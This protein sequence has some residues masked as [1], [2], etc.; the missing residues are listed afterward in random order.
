MAIF[1][2][3]QLQNWLGFAEIQAQ[4]K[5]DCAREQERQARLIQQKCVEELISALTSEQTG[6]IW[7]DSW[8][9]L[10]KQVSKHITQTH[11][12]IKKFESKQSIS[13]E[14]VAKNL[15][16]LP[17]SSTEQNNELILENQQLKDRLVLSHQIFKSV[18]DVLAEFNP[19]LQE[20]IADT[21][22][23][24]V[25]VLTMISDVDQSADKLVQYL[26]MS[27]GE[28]Q[29]MNANIEADSEAITSLGGFLGE[30]VKKL[31]DDLNS[32]EGVA[33]SIEA[34]KDQV[35][36]VDNISRQTTLL[37]FNATIEAARAGIHGKGFAIVAA[38]VRKLA[39]M[40]SEASHKIGDSI[41]QNHKYIQ[42]YLL[43]FRA[44]SEHD[45]EKVT[46]LSEKASKLAENY[47]AQRTF[48]KILLEVVQSSNKELS[49]KI[50]NV[51]GQ[52][53][54]QDI[55]RQRVERIQNAISAKQMILADVAQRL[56][57]VGQ[58]MEP[59]ELNAL[60][61]ELD[62]Y[63]EEDSRHNAFIGN[64]ALDVAQGQ[65]EGMKIDL[66]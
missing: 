11:Q 14:P 49:R 37:S 17:A 65:S 55:V 45:A 42:N 47:E 66:F 44:S 62:R 9:E 53:Q 15:V 7:S 28:G 5:A 29:N 31:H 6:D 48:Y 36:V 56:T 20:V 50:Q 60:K 40:S 24:A 38:E 32:F 27:F 23:G 3:K 1:S 8:P 33:Q 52:V 57:D 41:S 10:L 58:Q 16:G 22:S 43:S 2:K 35:A 59:N 46:E 4:I 12:S 25:G 54:F 19:K 64:S 51:Y 30:M 34:L 39:S 13:P 26:D 18:Q 63:L 61:E 21:E